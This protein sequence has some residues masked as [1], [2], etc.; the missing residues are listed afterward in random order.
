MNDQNPLKKGILFLMPLKKQALHLKR[1]RN[2]QQ[3]YLA[4]AC[5]EVDNAVRFAFSILVEGA[6]FS[7]IE[8][9]FLWNDIK[10]PSAATFYRAQKI[11]FQE[12]LRLSG[13][14]C[15]HFKSMMNENSTIAVDGSWSHRRNAK[16]C[17][18][19]FVNSM[20]NKFV[21]FEI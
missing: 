15:S 3:N 8:S 1:I 7:T 5:L 9:V 18:V 11:V 2:E 20:Q 12:I 21:D 13:E 17:A 10:T 14:S 16:E 4:N 6:S 19:V